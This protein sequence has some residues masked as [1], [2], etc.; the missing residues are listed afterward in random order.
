MTPNE[1]EAPGLKR[2]LSIIM[3]FRICHENGAFRK[4]RS[5]KQR[6]LKTLGFAFNF[7]VEGKH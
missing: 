4:R 6:N 5:P 1:F 7:G 3:V 2:S